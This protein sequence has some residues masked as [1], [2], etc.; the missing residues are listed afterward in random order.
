MECRGADLVAEFKQ[1]ARSP[2]APTSSGRT[3]RTTPPIGFTECNVEAGRPDP[4]TSFHYSGVHQGGVR[5]A[6]VKGVA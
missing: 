1:L 6:L 2:R 3:S 4:V 5:Q